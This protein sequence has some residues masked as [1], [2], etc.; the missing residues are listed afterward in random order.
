[1][2][3]LNGLRDLLTA[4]YRDVRTAV[5]RSAKY[6]ICFETYISKSIVK[7][8]FENVFY[9]KTLYCAAIPHL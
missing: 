3:F 7:N 6:L 4:A 1:M 5:L 9:V 8:T 2:T